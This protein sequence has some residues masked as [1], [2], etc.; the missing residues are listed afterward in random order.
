MTMADQPDLSGFDHGEAGT[1]DFSRIIRLLRGSA[2]S[3]SYGLIGCIGVVEPRPP[4]IAAIGL[5]KHVGGADPDRDLPSQHPVIDDR[6]KT[7]SRRERRLRDRKL[8]GAC[9]RGCGRSGTPSD[10][11]IERDGVESISRSICAPSRFQRA[12]GRS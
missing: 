8:H 7:S 3:S 5:A 4:S 2:H 12:I 10:K 1:D 11:L 9:D 6:G